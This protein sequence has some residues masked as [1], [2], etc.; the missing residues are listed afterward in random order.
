MNILQKTNNIKLTYKESLDD[1]NKKLKDDITV[2]LKD[3]IRFSHSFSRLFGVFLATLFLI[4]FGLIIVF[5]PVALITGASRN[6]NSAIL[7]LII[8]RDNSALGLICLLSFGTA[9]SMFV[10]VGD[11]I[12]TRKFIVDFLKISDSIS[13]EEFFDEY[14]K[15]KEKDYEQMVSFIDGDAL[16]DNYRN[17][18]RVKKL[19]DSAVNIEG[20]SSTVLSIDTVSENGNIEFDTIAVSD[21]AQNISITEPELQVDYD[22]KITLLVPYEK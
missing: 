16:T 9:C 3:S 21:F 12:T 17:Y 11:Y 2:S 18:K 14:D 13:Y 19:L 1:I 7:E 5:I 15:I 6:T 4:V 8:H 20:V 22:Y 10:S